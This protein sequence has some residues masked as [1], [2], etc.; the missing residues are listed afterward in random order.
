MEHPAPEGRFRIGGLRAGRGGQGAGH[1]PCDRHLR[2]AALHRLRQNVERPALRLAGDRLPHLH[3]G[4]GPCAENAQGRIRSRFGREAHRR[5]RRGVRFGS[6]K[7]DPLRQLAQAASGHARTLRRSRRCPDLGRGGRKFPVR[8]L[9]HRRDDRQYPLGPAAHP[10]G[11]RL[12]VQ[13]PARI[14]LGR[15]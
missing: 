13:T 8:S 2:S 1:A 11:H 9:Q 10:H 6:G 14:P 7:V 4:T 5:L 12:L 3:Q 15:I